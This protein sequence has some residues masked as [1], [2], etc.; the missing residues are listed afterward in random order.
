MRGHE[1]EN[2]RTQGPKEKVPDLRKGGVSEGQMTQETVGQAVAFS[3]QR[4]AG[5]HTPSTAPSGNAQERERAALVRA[6]RHT[7]T[8]EGTTLRLL[9]I[10]MFNTVLFKKEFRKKTT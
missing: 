1:W 5:A 2:A 7:G 4:E 10:T 9:A 8:G 3:P 6:E